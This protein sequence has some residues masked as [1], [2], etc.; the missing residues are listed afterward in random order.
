MCCVI[1]SKPR[2]SFKI[3]WD[4]FGG[5]PVVV[6]QATPGGTSQSPW[7]SHS[8]SV[9]L[10]ICFCAP[11]NVSTAHI[12]SACSGHPLMPVNGTTPSLMM[13]RI[14]GCKVEEHDNT[15]HRHHFV[16]RRTELQGHARWNWT[17]VANGASCDATKERF[18]GM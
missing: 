5:S 11:T 12:P 13:M 7:Q 1:P 17:F 8:Q 3:H 10:E 15:K 18:T 14:C 16:S 9:S 2:Q 6:F 4:R